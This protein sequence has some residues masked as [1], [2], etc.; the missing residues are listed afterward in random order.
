MSTLTIKSMDAEAFLWQTLK[1]KLSQMKLDFE[2][3]LEHTD[4]LLDLYTTTYTRPLDDEE[5]VKLHDIVTKYTALYFDKF[6]EVIDMCRLLFTEVADAKVMYNELLVEYNGIYPKEKELD[7]YDIELA[8]SH[9]YETR[10]D[11]EFSLVS[12]HSNIADLNYLLEQRKQA[13]AKRKEQI[14]QLF[15]TKK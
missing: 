2:L 1:L 15:P 12:L 14:V 10:E 5:Y 8:L 11:L 4:G 13:K 3:V 6:T 9:P 7:Q